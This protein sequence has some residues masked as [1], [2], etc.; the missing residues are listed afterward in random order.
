[1]RHAARDVAIANQSAAAIDPLRRQS[2]SDLNSAQRDF[3]AIFQTDQ[4]F[5]NCSH[6]I[7]RLTDLDPG[8]VEPREFLHAPAQ[9]RTSMTESR[10]R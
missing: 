6:L 5:V 9:A 2:I 8:K 4:M 10:N 1:M 3:N 7:D